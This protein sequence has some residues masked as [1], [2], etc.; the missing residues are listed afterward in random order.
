[1]NIII[2]VLKSH[3]Y[4]L[5]C[6]HMLYLIFN[7]VIAFYLIDL[8]ELFLHEENSLFLQ[9]ELQIIYPSVIFLLSFVYDIFFYILQTLKKCMSYIY[10]Y[11]LL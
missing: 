3:L 2:N 8:L 5:F 9:D 11:I 6:V 4:F 7:W 1:M 10:K